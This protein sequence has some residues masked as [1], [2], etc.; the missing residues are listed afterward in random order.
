MLASLVLWYTDDPVFDTV[1]IIAL[2]LVPM[3]AVSMRFMSAP[4]GRFAAS[5][6]WPS[7]NAR[8]GWLL[9]ELPATL[10]FWP[11]FLAGPRAGETV[12]M[13]LA[14]I[15]GI[16]YLNRGFIF[17][18]LIRVPRQGGAS[19]GLPVLAVGIFV[20]GMHGYLNGTFFSRLGAHFTPEWLGDPRF[21]FGV[22]LYACGLVLNV[23]SDAVV[24]NLRTHGE[25]ARGEKVYRI[26]KGGG[27]TFVTNPHYLGELMMWTGFTLFTW[28]L[29]GVFILTLSAANLIPRAIETHRWYLE[30]F[31]DYPRS[32]RVLVPFLF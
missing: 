31:P 28:S 22:A 15:W 10:C 11:F 26:P 5:R 32:R 9:M 13:V 14:G 17:P 29:P 25:V 16:H 6:R 12:P 4:Y 30:R 8:V 23:H 19:F 27:F 1:L 7:V 2:L 21:I 18:L 20:T 24:R 3:T